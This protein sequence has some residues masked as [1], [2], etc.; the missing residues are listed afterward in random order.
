MELDS[1]NIKKIML[2]IAFAV[3]LF[4]GFMNYT[5]V[6]GV[7]GKIFGILLP[8]ILGLC[9]AFILTVLLRPVE[10]LWDRIW[11]AK[12]RG[13]VLKAK[14]PVCLLI[15]IG[16]VTGV[17]LVL[18][19]M[20]VPEIIRT[21]GQIAEEFPTYISSLQ[22]RWKVIAERLHLTSAEL[23]K[24]EFDKEKIMASIVEF[25]KKGGASFFSKAFGMTASFFSGIFNLVLALVFAMY[26][27]SQKE[28]LLRQF[29]KL[30]LAFIPEK[31]VNA[32]LDVAG[33]SN[34]IFSNFVKG[35]LTE[36]SIIGVLCFIGMS[37][38]S[39]PYAT[40]ISALVGFTAL[41]P[42][43]GAFIG[44]GV[45]AFLILMDDPKKALWFI[46]FILVLQQIEGNLIY[47]RVVGKSVGLPGIWVFT[48]VA[49]GGSLFGIIGILI[50]VPTCSV[51]YTLLQRAVNKRNERRS[52]T[53]EQ[54]RSVV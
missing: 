21:A 50:S 2:L 37:I 7:I 51:L 39:F 3:F 28:K 40:A 5:I 23:P 33:I 45:G 42:V 27:L 13:K 1:K 38:F 12:N 36:A 9:I 32:M 22:D 14:R 18:L 52:K 30:L 35:Q 4:W 48:A 47:P 10:H 31:H 49:I 11:K 44:T 26:V 6:F 41:I 8:F 25:A 54:E 46:V 29:K 43:F 17:I 16:F 20:V 34:R 19:F 24:F 53:L 15:T